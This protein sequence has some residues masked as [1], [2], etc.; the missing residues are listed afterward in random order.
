MKKILVRADSSKEIGTGHIT[1]TL[2]LAKELKKNGF[3]VIYLVKNLPGNINFKIKKAGFKEI[4]LKSKDK[5]SEIKEIKSIIKEQNAFFMVFDHYGIDED[6]E[7][8]IKNSGVMIFS[9]DDL[10]RKHHCDILLNQNIYAKKE[11]YKGLVPKKCKLLCGIEFALIRDEFKRIKD[12]KKPDFDK[13]NLRILVTLG[14]A[15]PKNVT[16]EVMKALDE[17]EDVFFEADIVVGAANKHLK[18]LQDFAKNSEKGF[19]IIVDAKNMAE[20]MNRSDIGIISCGTTSIE[21]LCMKLPFIALRLA[22]NQKKIFEYLTKN[23]YAIGAKNCKNE[24]KNALVTLANDEETRKFLIEKMKNLSIGRVDKVT[25]TIKCKIYEEFYIRKV[26]KQDMKKIF[27]ISNDEEVR[28]NSF[29]SEK[30][31]FDNHQKWFL[32]KLKDRNILFLVAQKDDEV[33]AQ[34][35]FEKDNEGY[36]ISISLSSKVR[37]CGLGV[38]ILEKSLEYFKEKI[39]NEEIYAYIKKENISSIKIFEKIGFRKEKE[40]LYKNIPTYIFKRSKDD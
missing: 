14:G 21:A 27:D 2:V 26:K 30:I 40:I 25:K 32:N 22:D 7:K 28:R 5:Y 34:V 10:Y 36:I 13:K 15:D 9:F 1:R 35:R 16:F 38:K 24:I 33:F 39:G 29:N 19:N 37:G 11:D 12:I 31:V 6:Y 23:G 20:L 4:E 17:V 8:E 18:Q 3:D